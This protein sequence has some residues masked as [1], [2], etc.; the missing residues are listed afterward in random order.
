MLIMLS[1]TVPE[2]VSVTVCAGSL[3]VPTTCDGNV[4]VGGANVTEGVPPLNP[5]FFPPPQPPSKTT[6]QNVKTASEKLFIYDLGYSTLISHV[7]DS[8]SCSKQ[9]T[10][11][12]A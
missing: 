7:G 5:E 2:L 12:S 4:R 10:C 1:V 8:E 6:M 3:V 9:L 11:E